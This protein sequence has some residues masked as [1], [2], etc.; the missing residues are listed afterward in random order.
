MT[1]PLDEI[2]AR[3][4]IAT[5]GPWFRSPTN[6]VRLD[7]TST[8]RARDGSRPVARIRSVDRDKLWPDPDAQTEL[9]AE[10]I[11][12]AP[13]DINTLVG[14][15][16]RLRAEVA[17]WKQAADA[18]ADLANERGRTIRQLRELLSRL[19][20]AG[21]EWVG[22]GPPERA[23]PVCAAVRL[24]DGVQEPEAHDPDCWLAAELAPNTNDPPEG[25]Q[26]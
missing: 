9:D 20:W 7:G 26:P 13:A 15:V 3:W 1:D 18:E 25:S 12:H 6:G 22:E 21:T 14:E 23:C 5:P 19:E 10:A 17:E 11:A 16:E 2:K 8:V 4:A 24:G